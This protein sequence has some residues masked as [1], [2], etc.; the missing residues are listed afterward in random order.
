[1]R[2]GLTWRLLSLLV[3]VVLVAACGGTTVRESADD[4][5]VHQDIASGNA[6][7][8]TF[9]GTLT[10]DPQQVGTHEH[11][12]VKIPQGDSIEV[13]HNTTLAPSVPAHAGDIV[14]VHGLLYIDPGPRP[15]VHCTHAQTS[16]GCPSP[17]WIEVAG[18][19][20]E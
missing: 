16:S 4:A 15:G 2:D 1:M 20:Y 6:V 14:I 10:A 5:A 8:V 17:G 9:D 7:E 12:Q 13:D 11:L 18:T 19:Y 3:S